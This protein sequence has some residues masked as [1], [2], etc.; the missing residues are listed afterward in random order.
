ME[1]NLILSQIVFVWFLDR[2]WWV[3]LVARMNMMVSVMV[4]VTMTLVLR[5]AH[6]TCT[7]WFSTH[8]SRGDKKR[9]TTRTFGVS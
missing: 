3:H 2:K 6:S 4:T 7:D 8:T 5:I 1:L 9:L